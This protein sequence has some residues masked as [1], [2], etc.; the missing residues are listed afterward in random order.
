[1]VL[2]FLLNRFS[3][4]TLISHYLQIILNAIHHSRTTQ[5]NNKQQK[6]QKKINKIIR[7]RIHI[8]QQY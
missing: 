1:M 7:R 2:F 3:I 6:K 4:T 8:L 5:H